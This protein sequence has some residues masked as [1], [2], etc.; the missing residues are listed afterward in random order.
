MPFCFNI[1]I[2]SGKYLLARF[3]NNNVLPWVYEIAVNSRSKRS[4]KS[5]LSRSYSVSANV[6]FVGICGLRT[7]LITVAIFSVCC[8][9]VLIGVVDRTIA[10]AI[11]SNDICANFIEF[12]CKLFVIRFLWFDCWALYISECLYRLINR[13]Y[14]RRNL[15]L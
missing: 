2:I 7:A 10:V 12:L 13:I 11:V 4:Y 3:N 15:V 1:G 8:A 14:V 9:E 6:T 5:I